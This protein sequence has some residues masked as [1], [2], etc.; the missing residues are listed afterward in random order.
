MTG[1]QLLLKLLCFQRGPLFVKQS[2]PVQ[3]VE[4]FN[5]FQ[6]PR[7]TD[8][9]LQLAI[10]LIIRHHAEHAFEGS[11]Y[12][13]D[14]FAVQRKRNTFLAI[15]RRIFL[16]EFNEQILEFLRRE[17]LAIVDLIAYAELLHQVHSH[18][19]AEHRVL[20]Q[21]IPVGKIVVVPIIASCLL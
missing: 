5:H 6:I 13:T 4:E 7:I 10:D 11:R 8:V 1:R 16:F 2:F 15:D 3:G 14:I 12:A 17:R 18:H 21:T 19:E 9:L 20:L